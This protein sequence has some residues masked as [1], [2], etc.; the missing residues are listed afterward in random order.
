MFNLFFLTSIVDTR[1]CMWPIVC[2]GYWL[3]LD[4][5]G[6]R[7][8]KRARRQTLLNGT[9]KISTMLKSMPRNLDGQLH[10]Y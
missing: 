10:S 2:I 9:D 5:Q 6:H 4:W 3:L 1:Q 7:N 8:E